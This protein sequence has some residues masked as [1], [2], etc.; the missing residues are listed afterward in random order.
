VAA[1]RGTTVAA[2]IVVIVIVI[3][4]ERVVVAELR[5]IPEQRCP[6]QGEPVRVH[7]RE[8]A[9][10]IERERG[11]G[12]DHRRCRQLIL[13]LLLILI[14]LIIILFLFFLPQPG[15][16]TSGKALEICTGL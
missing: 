10:N 5:Q 7:R 6:S 13:F 1:A 12:R 2:T 3:D 9:H 16:G 14:L 4:V 15:H 11:H 8:G